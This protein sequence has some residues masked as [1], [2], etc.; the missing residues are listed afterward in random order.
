MCVKRTVSFSLGNRVYSIT[1]FCNFKVYNYAEIEKISSG[2]P[3]SKEQI[4][5]YLTGTFLISSP[6]FTHISVVDFL[7]FSVSPFLGPKI[8]VGP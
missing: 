8:I 3:Y 2:H 5:K 4:I 6:L 7:S 1:F